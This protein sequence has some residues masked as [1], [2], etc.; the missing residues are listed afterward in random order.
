[1]NQTLDT[2][3]IFSAGFGTRMSPITDK[4]PKPL[5]TVGNKTLLDHTIN[6]A[7]NGHVNKIFINTHYLSTQIEKHVENINNIK[8]NF[9]HPEIL[10][11]G[12]GLKAISP[13]IKKS[14]IFTSNVD[15]I[16]KGPNPFEILRKSWCGKKMDS[17]L[18]LIPVKNTIGYT[19]NG[20][21]Q[22]NKNGLVSRNKT[23][24]LVYSGLQIIK[25]ELC[26]ENPKTVFSLNE[27]WD[28]LILKEKLYG[29]IY[30]GIWADVGTKKNIGLAEKLIDEKNV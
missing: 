19:G 5:V 25:H 22:K 16:W 10:D 30:K 7:K 2:A 14:P 11:T 13:Q 18:M 27:I 15:C 23:S 1:M 3:I 26:L 29:I 21:F 8:V 12:G 17:L 20:D 28:D 24:E 4:T 6:L 9:E